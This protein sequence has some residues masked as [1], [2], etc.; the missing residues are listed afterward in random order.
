M[1]NNEVLSYRNIAM[2]HLTKA[3]GQN[4][5][6]MNN[7]EGAT[8]DQSLVREEKDKRRASKAQSTLRSTKREASYL[9]EAQQQSRTNPLTQPIKNR[10]SSEIAQKKIKQFI[11]KSE[12]YKKYRNDPQSR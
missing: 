9:L 1:P 6:S 7:I 10:N 3:E 8:L 5:M 11:S 4:F 12:A 2:P